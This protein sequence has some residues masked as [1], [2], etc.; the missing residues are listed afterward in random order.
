[1]KEGETLE[2]D[3]AGKS[4]EVVLKTFLVDGSG[5][6]YCGKVLAVECAGDPGSTVAKQ[7]QWS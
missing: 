3:A 2:L 1:M 5:R 4:G 6:A 7:A